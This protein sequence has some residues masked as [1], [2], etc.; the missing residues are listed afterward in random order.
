MVVTSYQIG[1]SRTSILD[2]F[3]VDMQYGAVGT[4]NTP[5]LSSDTSL[6]GE[7][8]RKARQEVVQ[9]TDNIVVSNFVN[10]QE[11]NGSAITESGL[12]FEASNGTVRQRAVLGTVNKTSDKE[13]WI[14]TRI[15]VNITQ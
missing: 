9:L 8:L 3:N 15:K 4:V 5:A 14:D 13:L 2:K 1:E 7:I 10:S 12:F 11:A 6:G